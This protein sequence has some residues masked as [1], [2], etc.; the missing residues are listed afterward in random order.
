MVA[1]VG[2]AGDMAEAVADAVGAVVVV[3]TAAIAI[4]DF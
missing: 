3:V 1:A 2:D 4:A